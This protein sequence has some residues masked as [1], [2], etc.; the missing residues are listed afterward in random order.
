MNKIVAKEIGDAKSRVVMIIVIIFEMTMS[1]TMTM[2][3]VVNITKKI[4]VKK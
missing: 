4:V 3:K 2:S 1:V